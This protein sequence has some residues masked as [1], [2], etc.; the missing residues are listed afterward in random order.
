MR[1]LRC[2]FKIAENVES[3]SESVESKAEK[4]K[5]K[6]ESSELR[7]LE[8]YPTGRYLIIGPSC[9]AANKLHILHRK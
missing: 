3:N 2:V 9:Q 4:I 1:A 5:S 7:M 8:Q 6:A